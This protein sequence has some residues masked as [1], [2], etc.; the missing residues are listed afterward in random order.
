MQDALDESLRL[1]KRTKKRR[2]RIVAILLI[3]SFIVSLDVFWILRQPGW[4]L[5]GDA[6]C[7]LQEH[8][9]NDA[10]FASGA[11]C[12][13]E[14]HIHSI[15]CYA[16]KTADVETPLDWQYL[17]ADYPYTDSLRKNLVGIAK[18]QVGYTESKQ[19]FMV[20]DA[21]IR[22]GY[23][24]YGA[25]YGSPY[26]NW[27][28]MF[29][30]FCLHYAGADP[31]KTPGNTGAAA[32]AARW[33]ALDKFAPAQGYVPSGGD[34]VF[35][36]D[37]TVG[38]VT[39]VQNATCYVIR[40]DVADCVSG[41]I[42]FLNDPSISG[43]GLTE[44]TVSD[45]KVQ[46]ES[47]DLLD[48]STG[49][50][51][52]IYDSGS[53]AG[54]K[55]PQRLFLKATR[56]ATELIPYLNGRNGNYFFTLLDTNNQELPK[57]ASG[58]YIVKAETGY[59]LTLTI[60]CKDGF[61]PGTY[62]YQLPGG[63]QVNGG[64]GSFI[65]TD[66]TNVGG[67]EV[68]DDGLITMVFNDHM[69]SRTDITISATMGILFHTQDEPLDFDGKITVTIERPPPADSTT[70][71]N[72]WGVQGKEDNPEKPDP[73]KIYWTVQIMGKDGS[74]IPGSIVTDQLLT[75][76][77]RYT[78]SDIA[79]GL[80]FG[81]SE[82]D[83]QT[84]A[85]L[86]WHTWTVLPDDPN[87]IWTETGWSYK[88][89]ETVIC[90]YCGELKLGND[91]WNY[92]IYYSSTPT[93]VGIVGTLPYTNRVT[94]DG[95]QVEG[96]I[97]FMHGHAQAG[98][99]KNG[100]FHGDANGGSFIWEFQATLPGLKPGQKAEYFWFIMDY[101]RVTSDGIGIIDHIENDANHAAIT[102]TNNG[103]TVPVPN[104]KYATAEDRFAWNNPWSADRNGVYYGRE[105]D[106][107][108][109]CNCT[110]ET[111]HFWHNGSCG[112]KYWFEADDGYWYTNGFCQC[113]AVEGD[114][115]FTF[116]YETDDLSVLETYGSPGNNLL[117]EAVLYNKT[118]LP[119]GNWDSVTIAGSEASVPIPGVFKKE[120]THD[121][122]G[123]TAHYQ[124]TV[125]E[126]KL[127]LTN[128]SPLNIHDEMTKTLAFISG[129]LV[130][131]AEDADGHT[132]KLRQDVDYT[133]T[134][135]GTG[136][137]TDDNG[138]PVHILEIVIL[139]PQPVMYILDYD[140]TLI[141]P[142]GTTRAVKYSN[143]A[144]ITLWG[145]DM[146]DTSEEKVHADINIAAKVYQVEM[147]KKDSLTGEPLAGATFGL[148][149][150]QGGLID[151]DVTDSKGTLLFQTNIVQGVILREHV[152]YYMQE[153]KAPAG[154]QLDDTKYW[155]C[156]CNSTDSTCT[157]CD[158]TMA[159][160]QAL[161]IPFEQIGKVHAVNEP[162]SYDLPATGG[163]GV[164]HYVFV[165]VV[166]TLTPLICGFFRRRKQE[167]GHT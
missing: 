83:P 82:T 58:N 134:Y 36:T 14:E 75:G 42:L 127:A 56:T 50:A 102:A 146:T 11:P 86:D 70:K 153:L 30:S 94:V 71:L 57:D 154:Y 85:E 123:Y 97:N 91:G 64:S 41:S 33:N 69:N 77:H 87:L 164:Y 55:K 23:T 8:T 138:N 81:V 156:F 141:I 17:F 76:D 98:I 24:R 80:R 145:R 1:F 9:H 99:V 126:A 10:C 16:D 29:V 129:S 118:Q 131:T 100:A 121:F 48:I 155:F 44:G 163:P 15:A 105:L 130:I 60:T 88:I 132:T 142:P 65:L 139:N 62:Q 37:N 45:L 72:K 158:A 152:L 78:A 3:L 147:H 116:A 157:A 12:G 151:S 112:S 79:A 59:K 114:T 66:G 84:G 166:L 26:A 35:F 108:C 161:R 93:P 117:N 90:K 106:L 135:D 5:A 22:H 109:R 96:W 47:P 4:T 101:L 137:V 61:L 74:N 21:G 52:F 34:L 13:C 63:L 28:A 140:A 103:T 159:D 165:G 122:D 43:W 111:C 53:N 51:V 2:R 38:I 107:L 119:D 167:R 136:A 20:D 25:W 67:W 95:Q 148:Y 7:R 144:T 113:W 54:Q 160:I 40:G 31:E 89:P 150:A 162:M 124:I 128:G 104:V 143:A 18:T 32:M 133:V 73:S 92:G 46:P 39:M 6:D 49:P 125:N 115:T 110:E 68:T 120:L 27:S 149:N 19:N